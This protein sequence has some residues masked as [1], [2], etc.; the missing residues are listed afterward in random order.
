MG[1]PLLRLVI[2]PRMLPVHALALRA[3]EPGPAVS[4]IRHVHLFAAAGTVEG[5]DAF[6]P[7]G[8]L[9]MGD[10]VLAVTVSAAACT[11]EP[12]CA[13]PGTKDLPAHGTYKLPFHDAPL[14]PY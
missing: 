11:A 4:D 13:P 14:R 1:A 3:A 9:L 10:P 6:R 7:A 2:F 8:R 12:L 5:T